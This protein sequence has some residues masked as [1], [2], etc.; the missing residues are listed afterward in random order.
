MRRTAQEV[1]GAVQAEESAAGI[2]VDDGFGV[3]GPGDDGRG[4]VGGA[5][6]DVAAPGAAV[7]DRAGVVAAAGGDALAVVLAAVRPVVLVQADGD[8][9]GARAVVGRSAGSGPRP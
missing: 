7:L 1:P 4:G 3:D 2:V 5:G 6:D 9:A 8:V